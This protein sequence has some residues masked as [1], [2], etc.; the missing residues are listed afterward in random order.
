MQVDQVRRE[1]VHVEHAFEGFGFVARGFRQP[2]GGVVD[3]GAQAV[4]MG[5]QFI[6]EGENGR[7]AGE[8]GEHSDRAQIPQRLHAWTFAAV[9]ENDLMAVFKQTLRAVQTDTLAGTGDENRGGG[10]GHVRLGS[11]LEQKL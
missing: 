3:D 8:V 6:D 2:F 10:N 4:G 1:Q 5:F 9:G 11:R 7:F